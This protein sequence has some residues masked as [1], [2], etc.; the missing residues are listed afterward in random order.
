MFNIPNCYCSKGFCAHNFLLILD[1]FCQSCITFNNIPLIAIDTYLCHGWFRTSP[2]LLWL[3]CHGRFRFCVTKI[4]LGWR[5]KHRHS[6]SRMDVIIL[7]TIE[8][9]YSRLI[10]HEMLKKPVT[11]ILNPYYQ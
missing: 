1:C 10:Q 8:Y 3:V 5:S 2:M 9:N 6:I 7:F 4:V 11:F